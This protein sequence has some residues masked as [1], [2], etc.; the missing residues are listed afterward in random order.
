MSISKFREFVEKSGCG[1]VIAIVCSVIMLLGITTQC[2]N[3]Q[4]GQGG[5]AELGAGVVA[6][7]DGFPLTLKY[8]DAFAQQTRQSY[9]G[10]QATKAPPEIEAMV[11]GHAVEQTVVAGLLLALCKKEGITLN[12]TTIAPVLDKAVKEAFLKQREEWVTQ[13]KLSANATQADFD[14][15]YEAQYKVSPKSVMEQNTKGLKEALAD[16]VRSNDVKIGYAN[17]ILIDHYASK[18]PATEAEVAKSFDTYNTKRIIL[19]KSK[20]PGEDLVKKLNDIKK[21]IQGGMTFEAAMDRYSDEAEA[22]DPKNP[23]IKKAK[24]ENIMQIDGTTIQINESYAPVA[25][26]K[27]GEMSEPLGFPQTV[28]L[29]RLDSVTSGA[30]A[31]LKANFAKYKDQYVQPR[32]VT[33]MQDGL[34]AL[35]ADPKLIAWASP[36]YQ[37]MYEKQVFTND[38]KN[39][40]LQ[41]A[42]REK[43]LQEFLDR[44]VKAMTDDPIGSSAGTLVAYSTM[45]EIY[46]SATAEKKKALAPKR[47]EVLNA[48]ATNLADPDVSLRLV[49]MY[50]EQKDAPKVKAALDQVM[51][52][53]MSVLDANGQ[54]IYAT[55]NSKI[56]AALKAKLITEADVT[57]LRTRLDDWKKA[58]L[59]AD[60]YEAEA[61]KLAEEQA[62]KDAAEAKRLQDEEKK[63]QDA[64]AKAKAK[65]PPPTETKTGQTKSGG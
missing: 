23:K 18:I 13:K 49:D 22:T 63:R 5:P 39:F 62:K 27:P 50:V 45:E 14:K 48:V 11:Q 20:H 7:V 30:P 42:D 10:G 51:N 12:E 56:D 28:E 31:D 37:V 2:N 59:S 25:K 65:T 53:L 33:K 4:Q 57:G 24:H 32:A 41:P 17:N 55:L 40:S 19:E 29:F 9:M 61:K 34:T 52:G 58:K 60:K 3:P 47:A 1:W 38:P 6:N 35:K 46:N 21:Q 44:A 43:K 16:P 54:R 15:Y 36:G 8:V 64:E 26:L